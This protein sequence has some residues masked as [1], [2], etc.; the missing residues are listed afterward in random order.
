MLVNERSDTHT[1]TEWSMAFALH[2]SKMM[3][4]RQDFYL[5]V[6]AVGTFPLFTPFS[7]V[8]C[9]SISLFSLSC[10]PFI[11]NHCISCN[12]YKQKT[13]N[14]SINL[15]IVCRTIWTQ[16]QYQMKHSSCCCCYFIYD[17]SICRNIRKKSIQLKQ[18]GH[19]NAS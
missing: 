17:L 3:T 7:F 2:V 10:H 18:S 19:K 4:I 8:L 14:E 15:E 1:H 9:V 12:F 5:S 6:I 16:L 13:S 11:S